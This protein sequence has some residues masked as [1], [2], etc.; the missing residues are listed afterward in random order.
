MRSLEKWLDARRLFL[1]AERA[2]KLRDSS[3]ET[4]LLREIVVLLATVV[5]KRETEPKDLFSIMGLT[6]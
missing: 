4:E 1:L 3:G 6:D 5:V 2:K